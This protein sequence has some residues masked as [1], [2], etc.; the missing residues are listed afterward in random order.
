MINPFQLKLASIQRSN[1]LL[2]EAEFKRIRLL[3]GLYLQAHGYM[4]RVAV[5]DGELSGKQLAVLA[6]ISEKYDRGY[7]H[8][9][10]RQNVQ[11]NWIKLLDAANAVEILSRVK[12]YSS[13]TAGNCVRQITCDPYHGI[14]LDEFGDIT[15]VTRTLREKFTLNPYITQL[16]RKVKICVWSSSEDNVL[17]L[18]SDIGIRVVADWALV[19]VGGGLGKCPRVGT[20]LLKI[21][22]TAL[23]SWIASFLR[24]YCI[25]SGPTR[26]KFL[27]S[28]LGKET[29][30][31]L[32]VHEIKDMDVDVA[33]Y[34]R[35]KQEIVVKDDINTIDWINDKDFQKW[36]EN[37]TWPHKT[38][39]LRRVEIG[40][41]AYFAPPGDMLASDAKLL[42]EVAQKYSMDQV[43]LSLNQT[44]V[45]P[46]VHILYLTKVYRACK[47]FESHNVVCCPGLDYCT[48]ANAR[49]ILIAQKLRL[50]NCGLLIRVS[51]CQNACSQHHV[52]DVGVIGSNKGGQEVYQI[53]VGGSAAAGKICTTLVRSASGEKVPG[54]IAKYAALINKLKKNSFES[55]HKCFQRNRTFIIKRKNDKTKP[56]KV[57]PVMPAVLRA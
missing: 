20:K 19:T 21:K 4:L 2:N 18:F 57:K 55:A 37:H 8:V 9:T 49:S 7:F 15:A 27:V 25:L 41:S 23:A 1:G 56:T 36:Y 12:L 45:L 46:Y 14:R 13:H 6:A 30:L 42:C 48:L 54:I 10:T 39:G 17:G 40:C 38:K 53:V 34:A 43:R 31:R 22:I 33:I 51:G 44:I 52:F 5:A 16:P 11:F 29:L 28:N 24:V 26:T 50:L 47:N 3:N 35:N 32:T